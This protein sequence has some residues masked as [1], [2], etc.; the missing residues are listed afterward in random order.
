ME[1][2]GE[3]LDDALHEIFLSDNVSTLDHLFQDVGQNQLRE[4]RRNKEKR[5]QTEREGEGGG[6]E[7]VREEGSNER[8]AESRQ[9]LN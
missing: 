2:V 3:D 4:E 6:S 7:G 1:L 5:Q 8:K 9:K